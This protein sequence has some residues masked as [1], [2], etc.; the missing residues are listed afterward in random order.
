M[1]VFSL[2]AC[3]FFT[4]N[5]LS[6]EPL[7]GYINVFEQTSNTLGKLSLPAAIVTFTVAIL[8]GIYFLIER[9]VKV[10]P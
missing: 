3:A 6:I 7:Q 9:K 10:E 5:Y 8:S 4:W 1:S 2:V